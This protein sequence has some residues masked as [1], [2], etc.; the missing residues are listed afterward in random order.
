MFDLDKQSKRRGSN[1]S[2]S[3]HGNLN[4]KKK[5]KFRIHRKPNHDGSPRRSHTHQGHS[6]QSSARG[7]NRRE[8][9]PMIELDV[10]DGSKGRINRVPT[11]PIKDF[12][13]C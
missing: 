7:N 3:S 6:G 13:K 4:P 11:I 2:A 8:S 10:L 12:G 9:T 5:H 1:S